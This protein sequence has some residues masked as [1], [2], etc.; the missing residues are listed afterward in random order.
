MEQASI[1]PRWL[2][3]DSDEDVL[4]RRYRPAWPLYLEAEVQSAQGL[5][6]QHEA[7][8]HQRI[9]GAGEQAADQGFQEEVH[10]CGAPR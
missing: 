3:K 2:H 10:P 9:Q 1:E 8:G 6:Y 7:D 5:P 4:I